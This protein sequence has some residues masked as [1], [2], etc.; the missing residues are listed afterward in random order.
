[1]SADLFISY[2]W[3]SETHREWVRLLAA[4]MK[5]IGYNVLVDADVDY[6]DG[7][8]GFMGQA[9]ESR[10]VLLIVDE[11]YV[12]RANDVPTSGVGVE[13]AWISEAH[14]AKPPG[15]LSVIFKDNPDHQLPDWLIEH[16]P[17]GLSFNSDLANDRSP[18]AAQIEDL[19]RW[20]EGLPANVDHAVPAAV[21]R[22]RARRLETIDQQRDPNSWADPALEGEVDFE[23]DRAPG[24][25]YS[26]G[27]G[28]FRFTLDVSSHSARAVYVLK[29]PIHAVG[30]NLSGATTH[31]EL[32]E[33]LT[34]G[35]SVVASVGQQAILQNNHGALCLVDILEVKREITT[36]EFSPA[37]VRFRYRILEDS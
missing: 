15:W 35:R 8:N 30:L 4:H 12:A 31:H 27:Y 26:L 34:P 19:W 21:L 16:N 17:K 5:A 37:S 20:I 7:L 23:F 29:D 36:P 3:T 28:E 32:A 18:G 25:H 9:T 6:G 24:R 22:E 33:Q 11:N 13:T 1:M 2:A 14:P 10:H